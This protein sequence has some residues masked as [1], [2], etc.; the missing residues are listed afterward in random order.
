MNTNMTGLRGF[1]NSL[2][3]CTSDESSSLRINPIIVY[4]HVR[5]CTGALC[6]NDMNK[7]IELRYFSLKM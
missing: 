7:L 3:L 1:Q 2:T 6:F 5:G 4:N